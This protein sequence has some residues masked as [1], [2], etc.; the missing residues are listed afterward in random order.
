[1]GDAKFEELDPENRRAR[2]KTHGKDPKGRGSADAVIDFK[3]EQTATGSSVVIHTDLKLS[4]A[5]AQYGRAA[6]VVQTFSAQLIA[7][8]GECLKRKIAAA[9]VQNDSGSVPTRPISGFALVV[10]VIW[11]SIIR[12][13]KRGQQKP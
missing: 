8:F 10:K 5:I 3:F 6:G 12:L 9:G 13:L 7:D 2:L 4:G 11:S 1:V